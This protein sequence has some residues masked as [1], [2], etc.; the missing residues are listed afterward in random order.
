MESSDNIRLIPG[1]LPVTVTAY[2]SKSMSHRALF[3]AAQN[4]DGMTLENVSRCEDVLATVRALRAAGCRIAEGKRGAIA[5]CPGDKASFACVDCSSS[6]STLRFIIP[7]LLANDIPARILGSAQLADRPVE[8]FRTLLADQP[9]TL[10]TKLPI[11]L[12]GHLTGANYRFE[13]KVSSQYATGLMLAAPSVDQMSYF[14]IPAGA[15]S[16]P[17]IRMT[18]SMLK[19]FGV[20]VEEKGEGYLIRGNQSVSLS[21]YQ[22][23]GDWSLAAFWLCLGAVSAHHRL[24]ITGLNPASVQGDI[25]IVSLL[26]SFGVPVRLG[27]RRVTVRP[28][29]VKGDYTVDLSDNPDLFPLLCAYAALTDASFTFTGLAALKYKESNR[30][31]S[32]TDALSALGARVAV[33]DD[34]VAVN[35]R[36]SAFSAAPVSLCDDHRVAFACALWALGSGQELT[37]NG[38]SCTGKSWPSFTDEL[39]RFGLARKGEID[40]HCVRT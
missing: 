26:R 34:S 28:C 17:Y 18:A 23:E 36:E 8:E 12:C 10:N 38:I 19:D 14:R 15:V 27:Q 1:K 4:P 7:Y 6:G 13:G 30:I 3:L 16:R 25:R 37:L 21:R 31:T 24:R 20:T 39:V 9:V 40:E 29:K 5:V 22:V 33:Y 11:C 2:P 32:V 35:G